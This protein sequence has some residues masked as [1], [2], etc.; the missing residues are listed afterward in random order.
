VDR[1]TVAYIADV[2]TVLGSWSVAM[3]IAHYSPGKRG[4]MGPVGP[5]GVQ[6]PKGDKGEPGWD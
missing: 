6:G 4:P 2:L 1:V 5:D 3:L